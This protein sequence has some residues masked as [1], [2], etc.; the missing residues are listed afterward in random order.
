[1][2]QLVGAANEVETADE[3]WIIIIIC[4]PFSKLSDVEL[5]CINRTAPKR[6]E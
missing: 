4:Q 5:R 6:M 2:K 1:M 3:V